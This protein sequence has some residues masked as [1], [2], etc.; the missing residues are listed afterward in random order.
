MHFHAV[1]PVREVDKLEDYIPQLERMEVRGLRIRQIVGDGRQKVFGT[2]QVKEV[3]D[4][5]LVAVLLVEF[6]GEVEH[7]QILGD[8]FLQRHVA[9]LHVLVVSVGQT[10]QGV[11]HYEDVVV[12]DDAAVEG[13]IQLL[14]DELDF[15]FNHE[16]NEA[17]LDCDAQVGDTHEEDEELENDWE[18]LI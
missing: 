16:A 3:Q 1:T 6:P 15:V 13:V 4:K 12:V 9:E 18:Q 17:D 7:L 5:Y 2:V 11:A 10:S 14:K 8:E